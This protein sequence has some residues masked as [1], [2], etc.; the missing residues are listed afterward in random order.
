[1]RTARTSWTPFGAERE[2]TDRIG[3]LVAF[4]VRT[5]DFGYLARGLTPPEAEF[6]FEI[7]APSGAVWEFGATDATQKVTGPAVD[8]CLLATRRRHR[9]DLAVTAS[10]A[11]ADR[12]L[13][14]AQC[15]RG[16]PGPGRLPGQFTAAHAG[17]AS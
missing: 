1:M 14:I 12:W 11:E 13:D 2:Y 15:Y 4:A 7:T 5:R 3:Y 9:G 8:F 10:G 16:S 6:R 17:T